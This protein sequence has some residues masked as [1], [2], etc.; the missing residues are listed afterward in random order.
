MD[1]IHGKGESGIDHSLALSPCSPVAEEELRV[2]AIEADEIHEA[3]YPIPQAVFYALIRFGQHPPVGER[4]PVDRIEDPFLRDPVERDRR[5]AGD[6]RSSEDNTPQRI[7]II[8][9]LP[10]EG[11]GNHVVVLVVSHEIDDGKEF[12]SGVFSESPSELLSKHDDR[13]R[14]PEHDDLVE[15]GNIHPR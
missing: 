1:I 3:R 7:L 4:R 15:R 11:D 8:A 10:E 12:F 5:N 9:V 2:D 13:L 14:R 6:R